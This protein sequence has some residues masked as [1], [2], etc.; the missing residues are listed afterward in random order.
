MSRPK[1]TKNRERAPDGAYLV[2]VDVIAWMCLAAHQKTSANIELT[3]GE[4][5]ACL[6]MTN[7]LRTE[8]GEG[9]PG[10]F[11]ETLPDRREILARFY[12]KLVDAL[13]RAGGGRPAP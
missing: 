7:I 8:I 6:I 9:L 3:R 2:D 13:E 5:E 1:G 4:L 12:D 10:L 11:G